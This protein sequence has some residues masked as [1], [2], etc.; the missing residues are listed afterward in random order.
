MKYAIV[1]FG[2]LGLSISIWMNCLTRKSFPRERWWHLGLIPGTIIFPGL[3]VVATVW[4]IYE[5]WRMILP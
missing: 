1:A 3:I 4:G 2:I 5:L